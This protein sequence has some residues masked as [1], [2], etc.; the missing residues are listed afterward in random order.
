LLSAI[1]VVSAL[2]TCLAGIPR[3][4]QNLPQPPT[5]SK[6]Q[7]RED[8]RY[9]AAELPKRHKNL[10]HATTHATTKEQF[11]RAVAELD[12]AIPSLQEHQIIVR[13]HQIAAT[14]GDGHTGVHLAPYFKR[15]PIALYWFGNELRVIAA[16]KEYQKALGARVV[17]I[18]SLSVNEVQKRIRTC[19]PSAE[20]ENEW[21][22]L[23]TSPAF[24]V[25]PEVLHALGI[26]S[27]P[28][29]ARFTFDEGE[30][31]NLFVTEISPV[32]RCLP[33]GT[34]AYAP[35]RRD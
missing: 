8:L 14:V 13:L 11:E 22:V 21:Y 7:W 26:I 6:D 12:A 28:G 33:F 4:A 1:L 32:T 34:Y 19:F 27:S 31:R 2:C 30:Q 35:H 25:V 23:S 17:R 18:G 29:P 16:A 20:N 3:A 15:Y 5:V 9:F 10:F 24:I